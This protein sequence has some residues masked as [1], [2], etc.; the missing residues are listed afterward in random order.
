MPWVIDTCLLIDIADADPQF[1]TASAT[2]LDAK[3]PEG[4]VISPITYAELAPVFDGEAARQD[5]FSITCKSR[6]QMLGPTQ[7]PRQPMRRGIAM[8]KAAAFNASPNARWLTFSSEPSPNVSMACSHATRATSAVCFPQ[9]QS[10]CRRR[11]LTSDSQF[12]LS[13]D[14]IAPPSR[15]PPR[16]PGMLV[17]AGA[18][19]AESA[20]G[21][22]PMT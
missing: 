8:S 13:H 10:S 4:L 5:S 3:R 22:E 21:R 6:G 7:K 14:P 2:L 11:L 17:P 20:A 19:T 16:P 9:C 18:R 12:P 15:H 1:A